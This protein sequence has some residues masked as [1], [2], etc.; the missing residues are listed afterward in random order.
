MLTLHTAHQGAK[1]YTRGLL[2]AAGHCRVP[3][4]AG[5]AGSVSAGAGSPLFSIWRLRHRMNAATRYSTRAISSSQRL[6]RRGS[7]GTGKAVLLML[8]QV[9][10]KGHA[11][12]A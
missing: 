2:C 11:D 8:L 7:D 12:V 9:S 3:V 10:I 1:K 4:P 6:R 5:T